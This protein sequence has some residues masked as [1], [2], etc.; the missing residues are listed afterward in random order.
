MSKKRQPPRSRK[1][2]LPAQIEILFP[3]AGRHLPRARKGRTWNRDTQAWAK[4]IRRIRDALSKP[5][6]A[7]QTLGTPR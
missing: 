6:R 3:G 2:S 5:G 7:H 1:L 4:D